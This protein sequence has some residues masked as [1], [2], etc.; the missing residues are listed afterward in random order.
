M[1]WDGQPESLSPELTKHFMKLWQYVEACQL[2]NPNAQK[3][4][5][6]NKTTWFIGDGMDDFLYN[7]K[8]PC[9]FNNSWHAICVKPNEDGSWKIYDANFVGGVKNVSKSQLADIIRTSLGQ[10]VCVNAKELTYAHPVLLKNENSRNCQDFINEGG[11]FCLI[12]C[13]NRQKIMEQIPA[14]QEF[15]RPDLENGVFLRDNQGKPAWLC[16]LNHPSTRDFT[17]KL[18]KRYA[19]V[20]GKQFVTD[21]QKSIEVLKPIEKQACIAQIIHLMPSS[22][23]D[24]ASLRTTLLETLRA[25]PETEHYKRQLQTWIKPQVHVN[26]IEEY[27]QKSVQKDEVKKRLIEFNSADQ[28]KGLSFALQNH[29]QTT[30]RPIFYVHSPDD[31]VCSSAFIKREGNQGIMSKG[32]GGPLHDFLTANK[33]KEQPPVILINYDTFTA[34]DIVRFDTLLDKERRVDG[35]PVSKDT[36]VIGLMDVS[37]PDCYQGSDFYSRFDTV[38]KCPLSAAQLKVKIPS[39]PVIES[40]TETKKV[41]NLFHLPTWEDELLGRWVLHGDQ[42][43]Y[44]EGVLVKALK[45]VATTLEIQNGL[46]GDEDFVRFWEQATLLGYVEHAG[47]KV[48]LPDNLR[49]IKSKGYNWD[50]LQKNCTLLKKQHPK[51]SS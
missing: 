37:K 10:L 48:A 51:P 32:P 1:Q 26:S 44:Q 24:T 43:E 49:I 28:L 14:N 30:K 33:D 7:L 27:C 5:N 16:G 40:T 50:E 19:E 13:A 36:L 34:E 20:A 23:Q 42:L 21:I 15:Q 4:L 8:G 35:T 47:Q 12:H 22:R 25:A 31:L 17:L 3:Q 41:I 39:L 2:N 29:C 45:E 18:L 6:I 9:F 11:L 46:W 38:E